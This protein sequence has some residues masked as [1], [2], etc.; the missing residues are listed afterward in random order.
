[1]ANNNKLANALG[2][3]NVTNLNREELLMVFGYVTYKTENLVKD[4]DDYLTSKKKVE[5]DYLRLK[6]KVKR[7]KSC[8]KEDARTQIE[9]LEK[10]IEASIEKEG[11]LIGCFTYDYWDDK[12]KLKEDVKSKL[13]E[14]YDPYLERH[15]EEKIDFD[16]FANSYHF[17]EREVE[18]LF[19]SDEREVEDLFYSIKA[20]SW[21]WNH[22]YEEANSVIDNLDKVPASKLCDYVDDKFSTILRNSISIYKNKM[23][24]MPTGLEE[25]VMGWKEFLD[26]YDTKKAK[27]E[28]EEENTKATIDQ[29]YQETDSLLSIGG[30]KRFF[31]S[32]EKISNKAKDLSEDLKVEE[33]LLKDI[34]Y[35][36]NDLEDTRKHINDDLPTYER[37]IRLN[38][39]SDFL[40]NQLQEFIQEFNTALDN[41]DILTQDASNEILACYEQ[42]KVDEEKINE[43]AKPIQLL[44]ADYPG[45]KSPTE[46]NDFIPFSQGVD[47][48]YDA[49]LRIVPEGFRNLVDL[50]GMILLLSDYRADNYRDAANLAREEQFHAKVLANMSYMKVQNSAIISA[51]KSVTR[52]VNWN[53]E[54][55]RA[56][57]GSIQATLDEINDNNRT[58]AASIV[59][60]I[61]KAENKI[62]DNI[63]NSTA[64][65]TNSITNSTTNITNS[66]TE[67]AQRISDNAT[68]NTQVIVDSIEECTRNI[69]NNLVLMEA[70]TSVGLDIL[71]DKIVH[72]QDTRDYNSIF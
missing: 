20:V 49:A 59:A 58:N 30:I 15:N 28:A 41:L 56:V 60:S 65:I 38:R 36:I 44:E 25:K 4:R 57:L 46:L 18:D 39:S 19:Y 51:V 40:N 71:A 61:D 22:A 2:S 11:I 13:K 16:H 50:N 70:T 7:I 32:S 34:R 35:E 42:Q 66:I 23:Q 29:I 47:D 68:E 54:A 62:S 63:T 33:M 14:F 17:D 3:V 6:S 48:K 52:A 27:L 10:D 21:L 53:G 1:M 24:S 12:S 64:N 43:L 72:G 8:L 67:N 69:D 45:L 26:N 31:I 37:F 9:G 55:T 5:N